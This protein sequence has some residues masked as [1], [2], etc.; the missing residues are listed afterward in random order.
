MSGKRRIT[1][2]VLHNEVGSESTQDELDVIAQV[3]SVS[4]AL[5]ALG[6]EVVTLPL[7]LDLQTVSARLKKRKPHFVF[8]LVE[9]IGGTGRFLYFASALLDH[10]GLPYSGSPTDA[11][12]ITTNKPLSKSWMRAKR[13]PTPPWIRMNGPTVKSR[14]FAPPYIIKP[15]WE[16]AS[17]GLDDQSVFFNR[18]SFRDHLKE[19]SQSGGKWFAEAYIPGREFNISVLADKATPRVLPVAEIKFVGYPVD[20]PKIVDYRAKWE[21]DSFE[22]RN[23]IR[24]FDFS[25][26]DD[27][28]LT[29]LRT[30]TL[31]CWKVFNLHGYARVDFRVDEDGKP[32]VLEINANPCISPDS[33]FVAAA[34]QAGLNFETVVRHIINDIPGFKHDPEN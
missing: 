20:K 14:V 23:T 3:E 4:Q 15:V 11:L 1:A 25:K 2:L 28:L 21:V 17:V 5:S 7:S 18:G 8:N 24:H 31:K 10:L 32:W 16:D 22:Y 29:E 34:E 30:I 13:I 27:Q 6:Y 26:K 33:G 9:S 12:Y 19:K